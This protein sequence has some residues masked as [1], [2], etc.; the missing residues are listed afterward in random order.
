[1]QDQHGDHITHKDVLSSAM[2][3]QVFKKWQD[4]RYKFGDKVAK[5]NTR[6]FLTPM[7]EDEEIAVEM[8]PANEVVIKFKAKGELQVRPVATRGASCGGALH[9]SHSESCR[10]A[11]RGCLC[12]VLV[13]GV[14]EG[15]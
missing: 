12:R 4:F 11:L 14:V 2:Y 5:L 15:D 6:A 9:C 1:M 10:C 8:A 7:K 13:A 3:P